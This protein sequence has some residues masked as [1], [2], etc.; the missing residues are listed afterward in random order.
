M[1]VPR[2]GK[3]TSSVSTTHERLIHVS[4]AV[5]LFSC[6]ACCVV[7]ACGDPRPFFGTHLP[8][9]CPHCAM[10]QIV[11]QNIRRAVLT[12]TVRFGA[13]VIGVRVTWAWCGGGRL[14]LV[15]GVFKCVG[16]FWCFCCR[17]ACCLSFGPCGYVTAPLLR[18]ESGTWNWP[19]ETTRRILCG[20]VCVRGITAAHRNPSSTQICEL[21]IRILRHVRV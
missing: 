19:M 14:R 1:V 9:V 16:K 4:L 10:G 3:S 13:M 8:A 7:D 17:V 21:S 11:L 12:E 2:S 15:C 5:W 6:G 18:G 20:V